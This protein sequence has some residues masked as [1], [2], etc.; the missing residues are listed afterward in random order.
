MARIHCRF[1]CPQCGLK[2]VL[3][4]V[5]A[6]ESPDVPVVEWMTDHVIIEMCRRHHL[7]SPNCHPNSL[8]DIKI[9]CEG[10]EEDWVGKYTELIPPEGGPTVGPNTEGQ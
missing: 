9:P 2:D 4:S 1:S 10:G 8:T 6:R 7:L 3:V 5:Q